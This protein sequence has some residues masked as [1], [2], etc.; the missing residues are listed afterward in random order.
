MSIPV[1]AVRPLVSLLA[2][3]AFTLPASSLGPR[4]CKLQGEIPDDWS[5]TG[6]ITGTSNADDECKFGV[7]VQ[8]VGWLA[9]DDIFGASDAFSLDVEIDFRS[10]NPPYQ[11]PLPFFSV[12]PQGGGDA[13]LTLSALLQSE[14]IGLVLTDASGL[15]LGYLA[16][17]SPH[18]AITIQ[19]LRQSVQGGYLLQLSVQAGLHKTMVQQ[20]VSVLLP[21]S[22]ELGKLGHAPSLQGP[23]VLLFE[24]DGILQ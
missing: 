17:D 19:G 1:S 16:I 22:V 13:I 9:K 2:A 23:G 21:G 24:P 12:S 6:F 11:D 14:S 8:L 18:S 7:D 4:D 3:L 5:I 20:T 10:L 15:V